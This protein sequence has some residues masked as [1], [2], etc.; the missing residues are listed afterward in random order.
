MAVTSGLVGC[1]KKGNTSDTFTGE[2]CTL[3]VDNR[4]LTIDDDAYQY[5][6]PGTIT[7]YKDTVELGEGSYTIF[8]G[9]VLFNQ[10]MGSGTYT[11]DGTYYDTLSE[12][13]GFYNFTINET[14]EALET[15]EF[16]CPYK[17]YIGGM[18]SWNINAEKF[19]M[20]EDY[21]TLI[22]AKELVLVIAVTDDNNDKMAQGYALITQNEASIAHTGLLSE[23]ITFTGS[24]KLV[25][26]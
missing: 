25:E 9:G 13:G 6:V 14:V 7:V 21:F 5:F 20:D 19:W 22:N 23:K 4:T 17:T 10:D 16:K 18:S 26:V 3:S 15:T 12:I 8:V 24:G 2:A 1:I 11:M